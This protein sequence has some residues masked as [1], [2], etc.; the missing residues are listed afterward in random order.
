MPNHA[1]V[2]L[3]GH[4]GKDPEKRYLPS[5]ESV[6]S[7]SLATNRKRKDSDVTTWWRC[8]CWGR[9]G[10][11]IAQY[12]RKGDPI[13]VTGEVC[14]RPWTDNDGNQR[15]SLDVEV[16]DF[17]FLGSKD[18]AQSHQSGAQGGFASPPEQRAAVT[19]NAAQG[20][21]SAPPSGAVVTDG[22]GDD[23]DPGVDIPF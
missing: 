1:H 7:F 9:R 23:F 19:Q 4:L 21:Y 16:R 17:S 14:N 13:L 3:A 2:T 15:L 18:A 10:E 5:G 11:A 6:T 12:L 22:A 20:A 8:T